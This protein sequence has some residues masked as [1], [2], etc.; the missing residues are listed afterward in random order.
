MPNEP[1][2]KTTYLGSEVGYFQRLVNIDFC[3]IIIEGIKTAKRTDLK[4][5]YDA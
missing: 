5:A 2:L 4:P 3:M 1:V